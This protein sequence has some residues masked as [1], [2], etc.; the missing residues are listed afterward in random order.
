MLV[1]VSVAGCSAVQ[2]VEVLA[3]L[4][5]VGSSAGS[6]ASVLASHSPSPVLAELASP[7]WAQAVCAQASL[8]LA[9]VELC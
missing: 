1:L 5:V 3:L 7:S 8:V 2:A 9:Q 4:S 6:A